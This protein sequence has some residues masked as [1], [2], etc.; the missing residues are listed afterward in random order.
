M[1][2]SPA[3]AQNRYIGR[4][5]TV[6]LI[7]SSMKWPTRSAITNSAITSRQQV[8]AQLPGHHPDDLERA[9]GT[10]TSDHRDSVVR[11]PSEG[12]ANEHSDQVRRGDRNDPERE[13]PSGAE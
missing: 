10:G 3:T 6:L 4:S 13:L 2:L 1:P 12:G 5:N 7:G 8:V 9:C 11:N